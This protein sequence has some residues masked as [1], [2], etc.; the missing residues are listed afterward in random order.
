M[1]ISSVKIPHEKTWTRLRK[2]R[3]M[4][5]TESLLIAAK[6]DCARN[7]NLIIKTCY[8]ENET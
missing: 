4:R 5:E 1:D 6:S 3:F 2:G 7:L 8:M